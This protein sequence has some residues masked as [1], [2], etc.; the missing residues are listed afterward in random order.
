MSETKAAPFK[1]NACGMTFNTQNDLMQHNQQ[2]HPG[3]EATT[4]QK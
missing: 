1:C 2:A 3:G 4:Q